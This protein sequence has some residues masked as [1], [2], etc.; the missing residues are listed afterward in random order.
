VPAPTG[1]LAVFVDRQ[2]ALVGA[3]DVTVGDATMKLWGITL[4]GWKRLAW[5]IANR[6]LTQ[7]EWRQDLGDEPYH[8]T[9]PGLP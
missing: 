4:A 8:K 6:H 3:G 5:R 9:C 1:D 7:Q 2:G